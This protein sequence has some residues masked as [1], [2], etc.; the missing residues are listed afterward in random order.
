MTKSQINWLRPISWICARIDGPNISSSF[1]FKRAESFPIRPNGD[2]GL[3]PDIS[4]LEILWWK[5]RMYSHRKAG[6]GDSARTARRKEHLGLSKDHQAKLPL[7]RQCEIWTLPSQR[8]PVRGVK[9]PNQDIKQPSF[10]ISCWSFRAQSVGLDL[11]TQ[12][13]SV[14]VAVENWTESTFRSCTG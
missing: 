13:E 11:Y 2:I 12:K 5:D 14:S 6:T 4:E 3:F 7:P 1:V 8:N 9:C 10:D